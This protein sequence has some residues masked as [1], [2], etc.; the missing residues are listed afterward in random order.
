MSDDAFDDPDIVTQLE[1]EDPEQLAGDAV[2]PDPTSDDP[3]GADVQA[4]YD[5][6]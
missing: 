4:H 1:D 6:A 5:G 3:D 2:E